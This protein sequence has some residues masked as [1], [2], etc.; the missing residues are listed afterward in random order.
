[1]GVEVI[2]PKVDMDMTTGRITKWFV[3]EGATVRA[4]DPLFE[5]ETDKAAMEIEAP[6]TGTLAHVTG[7]PD[8]D[9]AV[10]APVA[11]IMAEGETPGDAP[12]REM[13]PVADEEV[14][15]APKPARPAS[16]E[17]GVRREPQ[18]GEKPRATPLAR[19][20]A[21]KM[22]LDLSA[23]PGSGPRGRIVRADVERWTGR[24]KEADRPEGGDV[25]LVPHSQMR[26]TIARR[27]TASVRTVPHF[28]LTTECR[29]DALQALQAE[30][31]ASAPVTGHGDEQSPE[32]DI[33]F[34]DI[35]IKALGVALNAV[36]EANITWTEEAMAH[37]ANV[38]IGFA[39]AVDGGQVTPVVRRAQTKSLSAISGEMRK[40]ASR[41]R[42]G[43]LDPSEYCG[44]TTSVF[45]LGM[46]DV[47]RFSAIINPPQSTSLAVGRGERR[48]V[49]DD[50]GV[51]VVGRTMMTVTL[52]ADHRAIDGALA[53]RLLGAFKGLIE[54]PLLIVV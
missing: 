15:E 47:S 49:F 37:H 18:T 16:D 38:D 27:L 45:N 4:G 53:A 44:G 13:P 36:P 52:A 17:A 3:D 14:A 32:W 50:D 39:V 31:N 19:R 48:P 46:Y 33:S 30:L 1:M 20:V 12:L 40:L 8:I 29:I 7:A 21:R 22:G 5:I 28:Y 25:E 34:N 24:P 6:A 51:S 10:G 9:I 43:Q 11:W 23:I 26:L 2:L 54:E 41:A 42:S 35:I